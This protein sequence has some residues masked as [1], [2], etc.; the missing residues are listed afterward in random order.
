MWRGAT[1]LGKTIPRECV[2][3]WGA[4]EVGSGSGI[5]H[6]KAP[7]YSAKTFTHGR[8]WGSAKPACTG[9]CGVVEGW[10]VRMELITRWRPFIRQKPP[11]TGGCGVQPNL[12]ARAAVCGVV[13]VVDGVH[14]S[15]L[16]ALPPGGDEVIAPGACNRIH[17]VGVHARTLTHI[18]GC[19]SL[20]VHGCTH[21]GGLQQMR[22][23]PI[24]LSHCICK[25]VLCCKHCQL[26]ATEK[27]W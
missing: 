20:L 25:S 3:V 4:G 24:C 5:D 6:V 14:N 2:C 27:W 12:H 1:S 8:L 13:V 10:G 16:Q 23:S 7:T 9:G 19:H 15:A 21:D 11:R 17:T 18:C 22:G 26:E